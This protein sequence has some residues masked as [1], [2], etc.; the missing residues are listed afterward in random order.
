MPATALLLRPRSTIAKTLTLAALLASAV[1]PGWA[2]AEGEAAAAPAPAA[3]SPTESASPVSATGLL[4]IFGVGLDL[5]GLSSSASP[6]DAVASVQKLYDKY[7]KAAGFNVIQFPVEVKELGDKGAGRLAKLCV[8]A[9]ANNVRLAPILIGA[10]QGEALPGD[11]PDRVGS[12]AAKT[13]ELTGKAGDAQAY[14][15]IMLY[16]LERPLNHPATHGPIEAAKAAEILK[17]TVEKLHA[18]EQTA[19]AGTSLQAT[20]VLVSASFDY[21]LIR[22]GAIVNVALTDESYQQAYE[23]LRGYLGAVLGSA[24]VDVV[25]L[26]WFP[27]SVSADAVDRFPDLV[28]KLQADFPGKLLLIGTGY[29][30]AA[31]TEQD[32]SK[33]YTQTFNNLSDLRTNQGVE[34]SFAGILWRT[35]MDR[36][37]GEPDP[38]SSKTLSELPQWKWSERASELTR[39]WNTPG[40]DSKEM[41]WWYGRVESHFGLLGGSKDL[42]K[43]GEPKLSYTLLS[44]LK[45][46]LVAAAASTGAGEIATQLASQPGGAKG[47]AGAVKE[48]LQAALFGMLDAWIAKTAENFVSGGGSESSGSSGS[49]TFDGGGG[50]GAPSP[51]TPSN[52]ADLAISGFEPVDAIVTGVVTPLTFTVVNNGAASATNVVLYLRENGTT[53]L[54]NSTP[55]VIGPSGTSTINV[56]WTPSHPGNHQN[57]ILEAYCDNEGAQSNNRMEF[58]DV[59]VSPAPSGGGG[60]GGGGGMGGIRVNPGRLGAMQG[61]LTTTTAPGFLKI[62]AVRSMPVVMMSGMGG[63]TPTSTPMMSTGGGSGVH[64]LGGAGTGGTGTVGGVGGGTPM[65]SVGGGGGTHS[66]SQAMTAAPAPSGPQPYSLAFTVTN[67]FNHN[68]NDV[69]GTLKI[70]NKVVA[71]RN[72]GVLFPHQRRTVTFDQWTPSKAG[73][74]PVEIQLAGTGPGGRPL[75][76]TAADRITVSPSAMKPGIPPAPGAG[77]MTRSVLVGKGSGGIA[78]TGSPMTAGGMTQTRMLLPLIMTPPASTGT[79]I[80]TRSLAMMTRGKLGSGMTS[81]LGVTANSILLTPYPPQP[82]AD[83]ALSVRLF[84]S[85]RV[86]AN[87]VKVEAYVGDEKLGEASVD[88]P[89]AQPVVASGFKAWK[90]KQGRYDVRVVVSWADR[91]GSASKPIEIGT[92]GA[93]RMGVASLIGRASFSMPRLLVTAADVRLNPVAPAAGQSVELSVR[94]MNP[95]TADAKGVRVELFADQ[96]KIGEAT[97]D[98]VAGKDFIFTGFPRWTPAA[99]RHVLLCRATVLGQT[100]EATRDVTAGFTATLVAP[101]LM[102]QPGIVANPETKMAPLGG[103]LMMA[104]LARPDLQITPADITYAPAMPKAGDALTITIRVQNVGSAAASGTV[105]GVLQVDGAESAR[106]EFPV[107]IAPGGMMSLMWPVTTPSGSTL[108]AVA[109]A[110]V[111]NDAQPGNNEGRASTSILRMIEKQQL[112]LPPESQPR[113]IR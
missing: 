21:E 50:G 99:G 84:N 85:E 22:F 77:A 14:S 7:L 13:V 47:V 55:G 53:D 18:S 73:T 65:G 81:L 35:A 46:S 110:S 76:S 25:S 49:Q 29:S 91:S 61:V 42:G 106:R 90:A 89:V 82:G 23:S 95:G 2:R 62:E 16:Q 72:L 64:V 27:G 30:T 9:K 69:R 88:V 63:G 38:P 52:T 11:F 10:T 54:A 12:F 5:D 1:A 17:A 32:Q 105:T 98:I 41:R 113:L 33:Y 66:T 40:A 102:K 104:T 3:Q 67:P 103:T 24:A 70:E 51:P 59:M 96:V 36:A 80:Q 58:G 37:K 15:Q 34:S 79:P 111:A 101:T 68:F 43:P 19:L 56:P 6:D 8:W 4:P 39:M 20:P 97:G 93:A 75:T 87:K 74:F 107:S 60:G 86:P 26:E 45:T 78:S 44:H 108:M 92:K 112:Q 83:M 28:S 100:T 94:A 109:T 48:K 57:V 31:G 71:T